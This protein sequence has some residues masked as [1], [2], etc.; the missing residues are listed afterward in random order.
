MTQPPAASCRA[1]S[2]PVE[3]GDGAQFRA[4]PAARLHRLVRQ[5]H[6]QGPPGPAEREFR[7]ALGP[8]PR[9][10][11]QR[12]QRK[13]APVVQ[14]RIVVPGVADPAEYLDG[15]VCARHRGVEGDDRRYGRGKL[16]LRS[17]GSC[18]VAAHGQHPKRLPR[19]APKLSAS[20][21]TGA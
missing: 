18:I 8:C 5:V 9:G 20:S 13:R 11:E 7:R 19:P 17:G 3:R 6:L 16:A 2:A 10:P 15:V 21:R 14:V 1:C 12:P 4:D